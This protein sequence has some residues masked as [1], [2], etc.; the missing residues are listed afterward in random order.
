ME[1]HGFPNIPDKWLAIHN[2]YCGDLF[3][4]ICVAAWSIWND[5]NNSFHK[6]PIPGI[7]ERCSWI[8]K[9]F[10]SFQKANGLLKESSPTK[11]AA[12]FI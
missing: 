10:E 5:Q 11:L 12:P 8:S 4:L 9:Y 2:R 1:D 3:E 6:N 7:F